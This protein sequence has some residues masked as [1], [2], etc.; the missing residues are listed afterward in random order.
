MAFRSL[1]QDYGITQEELSQRVGKSRSAIANTVRLLDLPEPVLLMVASGEISSGHG[2]TLLGVKDRDNMLLLAKK[3]VELDL[4][5]RQ[6]EN[7][8]KIINK[9][10]KPEPEEDEEPIYVDYF[11][12][13]EIRIQSRLGRRA[14]IKG[15]GRKKSLTLFYEDNE[16][17]D[18]L[19]KS[20]CGEDFLEEFN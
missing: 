9:P 2:R 18:E 16:D 17:L 12:E 15:K 14:M 10:Q 6:L 19:L 8:V 1:M 11:R 13:M 20:I 5:V 7:E 3:I 4:S